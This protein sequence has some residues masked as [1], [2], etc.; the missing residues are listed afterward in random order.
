MTDI[1]DA[2]LY[3]QATARDYPCG[4]KW[5]HPG[6]NIYNRNTQKVVVTTDELC[7][8]VTSAVGDKQVY[9][10]EQFTEDFVLPLD[11][12]TKKK[13][14]KGKLYKTTARPGSA[15]VMYLRVPAD[16]RFTVYNEEGLIQGNVV[17]FT[18]DHAEGDVVICPV[19]D[20][21]GPDLEHMS[22]MNG[23]VFNEKYG[24]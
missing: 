24:L 23:K 11:D 8:I 15:K 14:Q 2:T 12:K 5:A 9:N 18:V 4:V 1:K 10:E 22:M 21:G 7:Y 13:L 3:Q 16:E 17:D 6:M 19:A 20:D